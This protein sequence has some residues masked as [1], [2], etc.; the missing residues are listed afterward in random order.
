M[1]L[2]KSNV[3]SIKA[4]MSRYRKFIIELLSMH[5]ITLYSSKL[6]FWPDEPETPITIF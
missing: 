2:N 3:P 5:L 4:L 6:F 1:D